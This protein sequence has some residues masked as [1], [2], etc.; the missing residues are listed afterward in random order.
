MNCIQ[1]N[2]GELIYLR[3]E[4]RG[5]GLVNKLHAYNLQDT[6]LDAY[7]ANR[8]LGFAEDTRT[9][10][11]AV[12][13]LKDLNVSSIRLLTNNPKKLNERNE[14][15]INVVDRLPVE[16]T[17]NQVNKSYLEAKKNQMGHLLRLQ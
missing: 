16:I 11:V 8:A 3:Q 13:I 1:E 9:Y 14:A 10:K 6:G 2:E 17:P 4:G 7:E 12:A 5:I 15:G